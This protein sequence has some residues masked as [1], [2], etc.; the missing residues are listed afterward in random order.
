MT[1]IAQM[2]QLITS[3]QNIRATLAED[4]SKNNTGDFSAMFDTALS[5]AL[6]E[7]V[8]Q[9]NVNAAAIVDD[10][11]A[12]SFDDYMAMNLL[13]TNLD[14][15]RAA[16]PNMREFMDATGASSQDASELL[17]GVIGSNGDYRDWGAIMASDN[18]IDAAR[19]ATG[20]LYNSSLT[21]ELVNDASYGTP[22]FADELAAK[23]LTDETTL[24]KQGNFALHATEDTSSLMAVS[25]SGLLLRGAG[26]SQEQIERT[27]W[28][29]GFTTE[30]LGSLAD[31]A[32]TAALKDALESFA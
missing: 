26:S 24:G 32:E 1:T 8:P 2:D 15:S 25:S 18:P 13:G 14:T 16:R 30:G 20:Q 12:Q 10:S 28:L 6:E 7:P 5:N 17:Y 23:S 21:Y 4:N 22:A 27:A 29:F 11:P 31:K 3:L 9:M 19:A